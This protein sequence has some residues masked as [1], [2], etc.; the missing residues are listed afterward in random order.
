MALRPLGINHVE[1]IFRPGEREAARAFFETMGFAVS[2]FGPWL[3]VNVDPENANGIDNV[4]YASEPVPAQQRFEEELREA[5]GAHDGASAALEHYREVRVAHPQFN[6]HF[7][8][9]LPT[10]EIWEERTGRV[11]EA[12]ADHPLLKGRVDVAVFNPGDPGSV[13]PIHQTFLLTEILSTGTL[14]TGLIFELQWR[15]NAPAPGQMDLGKM[16][17]TATY[18]DPSSIV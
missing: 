18:P 8:A 2:D 3:V 4:M 5:L 11:R 16:A 15:P 9:S 10:R 7:G 12:A 1:M 6:F 14:Q 13:G 17:S